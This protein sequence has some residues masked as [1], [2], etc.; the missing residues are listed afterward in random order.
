[1]DVGLIEQ[2]N[3]ARLAGKA[4]TWHEAARLVAGQAHGAGSFDSKVRR[5]ERLARA[6]YGEVSPNCNDFSITLRGPEPPKHDSPGGM[7]TDTAISDRRIADLE[8]L[9]EHQADALAQT[10]D[11]LRAALDIIERRLPLAEDRLVAVE[12]H[13]K[14]EAAATR[15]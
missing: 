11:A 7:Q 13:D 14:D 1:V 12:Q 9:V 4:A 8:R 2:M 10:Q 15:H 3:A 6:V 5:L